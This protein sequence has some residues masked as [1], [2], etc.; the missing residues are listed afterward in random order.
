VFKVLDCDAC[1]AV[2]SALELLVLAT[3]SPTDAVLV[4]PVVPGNC[5]SPFVISV[6][7][8]LDLDICE[9]V[10]WVMPVLTVS[11]LP[12][13]EATEVP[14][15]FA[16]LEST[17]DG[18]TR[19][20][21]LDLTTSEFAE[22]N[23]SDA[24]GVGL[25]IDL[26]GN[27][28]DAPL[29]GLAVALDAMGTGTIGFGASEWMVEAG[30]ELDPEEPV[31]L[32][33]ELAANAS[34]DVAIDSGSVDE[35]AEGS[36][37]GVELVP[38]SEGVDLMSVELDLDD[39][40]TTATV[41]EV[42]VIGN[43]SLEDIKLV[44]VGLVVIGALEIV[45]FEASEGVSVGS[46]ITVE[47]PGLCGLLDSS[48]V[49]WEVAELV[50]EV[51]EFCVVLRSSVVDCTVVELL[52]EIPELC[53]VLSSSVVDCTVAEL[54]VEVPGLCGLLSSSVVDCTVVEL[55][56]EIPELCVVLSTSVVDCNVVVLLGEDAVVFD[57]VAGFD[58]KL[59]V[60][61]TTTGSGVVELIVEGTT[62]GSVEV[63]VVEG[64]TE[65]S[66][67]VL[68]VKGTTGSGV[69][70][71]VVEGTTGGSVEVLVVEGTT[72]SS[73]EV[74][75]VKG[76]TGSGVEELVVEGTTGGSVEVLVVE[77]TTG[78]SVEV[79][80]VDGMTGS[81]VEELV[82]E[83]DTGGGVVEIVEV[84]LDVVGIVVGVV[85]GTV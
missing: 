83:G 57:A 32:P 66:V 85:S 37:V 35:V 16:V 19:A 25:V 54:V 18:T 59:L 39:V 31:E 82:V 4:G 53:V 5:D 61:E 72:G 68:V 80:I 65:S 46:E 55:L 23:M 12:G 15:N 52:V 84:R 73:V 79:L 30:A 27:R 62:G 60:V 20:V 13:P 44:N 7:A 64:T 77:G 71:L 36:D 74:L 41:S 10:D 67:E 75:V 63:L 78:S 29:K 48:V 26:A 47:M 40:D 6:F 58:V 51:S 42:L 22:F 49:D 3:A 50:V 1:D 2:P 56:V 21:P 43:A 76:M 11:K 70:E 9:A 14:L 28:V 45:T 69:E 8:E 24:V 33:V 17:G 34:G 38:E 81:G